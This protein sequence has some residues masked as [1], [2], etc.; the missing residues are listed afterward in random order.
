MAGGWL[1]F[2]E[3]VGVQVLDLLVTDLECLYRF[4]ETK[5]HLSDLPSMIDAILIGQTRDYH[6]SVT[7]CLHLKHKTIIQSMFLEHV[8]VDF[9]TE[10]TECYQ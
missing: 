3:Y 1:G 8:W 4:Q 6:I 9:V 2:R 5:A 10:I 7:Y